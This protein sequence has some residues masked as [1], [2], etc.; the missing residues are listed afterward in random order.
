[1][2]AILLG[3]QARG[4]F[5]RIA[6]IEAPNHMQG[7]GAKTDVIVWYSKLDGTLWAD[8]ERNLLHLAERGQRVESTADALESAGVTYHK[9]THIRPPRDLTGHQI[10][11]WRVVRLVTDGSS[12]KSAVWE[13]KH[14]CRNVCCYTGNTIT[15]GVPPKCRKCGE[16]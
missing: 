3:I 7:D 9:R 10:G 6:T 11:G 14:N 12:Y 13:C 15:Y 2:S 16:R 4:G 5:A 1:M 8:Y